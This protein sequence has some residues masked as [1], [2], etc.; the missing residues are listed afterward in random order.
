MG[1]IVVTMGSSIAYIS[2][3]TSSLTRES[4]WTYAHDYKRW[5]DV[6]LVVLAAP[7]V[8]PIVLVAAIMVRLDG[9][10]AFYTQNRVGRGGRAFRLLKLR[11]MVV[12]AG[13]VL[14]RYLADNPNAAAEWNRDQKLRHDPRITW[15][16][17]FLRKCSVDELP[18][19]WNVL[20]G[21]MS[22][23]GPRP[24]MTKQRSLYSGRAYYLMRPGLTGLWQISERS[25]STFDARVAYDD[26]Y[27]REQSLWT[28]IKVMFKTGFVVLR[29]TGV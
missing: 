6:A 16:G 4:V 13:E 28:D 22:L 20:T 9:G 21:A 19:L 15:I 25:R 26:Q 23:V 24:M 2:G 8:F 12:G 17:R 5:L 3:K 7:I 11:T 18:Q 10:P 29:G 14:E 27:F 1:S